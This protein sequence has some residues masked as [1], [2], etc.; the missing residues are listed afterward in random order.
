M[1]IGQFFKG[2]FEMVFMIILIQVYLM[3]LTIDMV[4]SL[5]WM[6]QEYYDITD[7]IANTGIVLDTFFDY[8]IADFFTKTVPSYWN[9]VSKSISNFK[10]CIIFYFLEILGQ[11]FYL[12]FRIVFWIFCLD[13]IERYIWGLLEEA[14]Q[15]VMGIS[16]W[17]IIHWPD[18]VIQDCYSCSIDAPPSI[19]SAPTWKT[20]P[21]PQLIPLPF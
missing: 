10:T 3:I 19:P 12:P 6:K 8:T 5:N 13:D 15:Y 2:L 14:D 4:T 20:E 1:D 17:H 16:G 18:S 11:L 7:N 9:C 21:I